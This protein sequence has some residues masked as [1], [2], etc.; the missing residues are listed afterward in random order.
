M[1]YSRYSKRTIFTNNKEKYKKAF[2]KYERGIEQLVQ[3]NSPIFSYPQPGELAI[4]TARWSSSS[5][6][7]NIAYAAY[8]DAS[9]WWLIAWFNQKPTEAHWSIGDVVYIPSPPDA[10]ISIFERNQ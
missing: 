4:D 6:M 5:K 2:F 3:Y 1:A 10:A 8:G 9:L 7:Y